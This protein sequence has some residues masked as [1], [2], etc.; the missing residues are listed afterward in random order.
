MASI[1]YPTSLKIS[2]PWLIDE[3]K[4]KQLDNLIDVCFRKMQEETD[5]SINTLIDR[6]IDQ[7]VNEGSSQQAATETVNS[8]RSILKSRIRSRPD[9]KNT[10]VY[11]TG[12]RTAKGQNFA[13][14]MVLPHAQNEIPR[15]FRI[16]VSAGEMSA[17]VSLNSTYSEDFEIEVSPT[18]NPLSEEIFGMLH[19]W[20][21]DIAPPK[22][23]QKWLSWG[24]FLPF[25]LWPVVILFFLFIWAENVSDGPKS[26]L[27][28]EARVLLNQGINPSNEV[29]AMELLLSIESDYTPE[30]VA[31]K[32]IPG[33]HFWIYLSLAVYISIALSTCPKR[34]IGVWGGRELVKR[35]RQWIKF[36]SVSVP[37]YFA[38]SICLPWFLHR[39]G[40][41]P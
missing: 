7:R 41:I 22:W 5:R 10:T 33:M 27:K 17:T 8:L 32:W 34:A 36:V 18:N 2:G 40:I 15:G 1:S 21:A 16:D 28:Q 30:R 20:V 25:G 6:E 14:L 13:E 4:L 19:N 23:Q 3:E 9:K 11:L 12:G 39:I 24:E 29:R 37:L 26:N 38:T 35:K 31:V